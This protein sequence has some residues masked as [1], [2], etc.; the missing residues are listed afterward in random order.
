MGIL[1][2][3][4]RY[5]FFALRSNYAYKNYRGLNGLNYLT[6]SSPD[7]FNAITWL[8]QNV[9]GQPVITEAVGESYTRF[10]RVSTNTGLPTILGWRVHEW[11]GSFDEPGKRTDE[12]K[13]IYEGKDV[14]KTQ[15][16]LNK[17]QVKYLFLG[18][19]ERQQYLNINEEK[20]AKIG[21][22]VYSSGDTKIFQF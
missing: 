5:P 16:L 21:K 22:I 4:F 10:G 8:N 19:M 18:E 6:K 13:E 7:D 11:R 14:G 2:F 12:V 3:V 15:E 1:F 9:S 17:Y 20:I